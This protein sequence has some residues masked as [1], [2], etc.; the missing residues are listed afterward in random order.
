MKK[1]PKPTRIYSFSVRA[2]LD[3]ADLLPQQIGLGVDSYNALIG[4]ELGESQE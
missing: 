3:G 1:G 2:V 4:M